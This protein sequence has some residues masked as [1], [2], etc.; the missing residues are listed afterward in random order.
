M[1]KRKRLA[2]I[3]FAAAALFVGAIL[4]AEAVTPLDRLHSAD[5]YEFQNV[6]VGGD[7]SIDGEIV[8]YINQNGNIRVKS[9]AHDFKIAD[10]GEMLQAWGNGVIYKNGGEVIHSDISGTKKRTV[11]EN[12]SDYFLSGNWIYYT[13]KNSATLKKIRITDNKKYDVG[14]KVNGD[15]AVRGNTL[16]FIGEK[17]Y[18]YSARTDGSQVKPFLGRKIDSFMFYGN[19][20]YFLS[21]GEIK[22]VATANT[23]SIHTYFAADCFTV[24]G[25]K[26]Y[27]IK[28]NELKVLDLADPEAK[29]KKIKTKGENPTKVYVSGKKL[30]Y[31][32]ADGSL[33][34]TDLYG[35]GT[36]K[37]K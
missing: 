36:E 35:S 31:Y 37:M 20:V 34:R 19:Y 16:V 18:L 28:D 23:S 21:D 11:L 17:N 3:P 6:A 15:F 12:V 25:D 30:Y 1:T 10:S 13:E 5:D 32:L 22:S 14:V 4:I 29:P 27:F 7:V 8:Y 2:F 24:Y 9:E 33:Y 26:L